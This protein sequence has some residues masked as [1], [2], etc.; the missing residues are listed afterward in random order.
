M[1]KFIAFL[2][3]F[4]FAGSAH[5]ATVIYDEALSGDFAAS[6]F[7]DLGT[8]TTGVIRG[9]LD[10]GPPATI[11]SD[12][13]DSFSFS[14]ISE[15]DF[16]ISI[17]NEVAR[18]LGYL[19]APAPGNTAFTLFGE[20]NAPTTLGAGF[21][22][23]IFLPI[24]NEGSFDYTV[25]FGDIAPIPLPAGVALYAPLVLGAGSM[26]IRSKRRNKAT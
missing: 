2:G 23:V 18:T 21:Y 20:F 15:V 22:S 8:I 10:G 17:T 13:I 7:V 19:W 14:L 3:A 12:E 9:S 11:A 16:S 5:A 1:K 26:A 4:C 24:A 6:G 25:Q